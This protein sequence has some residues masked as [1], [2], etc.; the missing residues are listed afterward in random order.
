MQQDKLFIAISRSREPDFLKK[1]PLKCGCS[2]R[3]ATKIPLLRGIVLLAEELSHVIRPRDDDVNQNNLQT[4]IKLIPSILWR[5]KELFNPLKYRYFSIRL[6]ASDDCDGHKI[7]DTA[8]HIWVGNSLG[9]GNFPYLLDPFN[10][11]L[12]AIRGPQYQLYIWG[13]NSLKEDES[14]AGREIATE[15]FAHMNG[16]HQIAEWP[17]TKLFQIDNANV[18]SGKHIFINGYFIN[19]EL[20]QSGENLLNIDLDI[21]QFK[22]LTPMYKEIDNA[23]Y[24]DANSNLYH[25]LSESLRPL[26]LAIERKIPL[27][28]IL[29]RSG[30]P[31]HFYQLINRL[32]P[33][34][35]VITLNWDEKILINNLR[36]GISHK[37]LSS[38]EETFYRDNNTSEFVDSDEMH[39]WQ[40]VNRIFQTTQDSN[41][42][43][44]ISRKRNDSR[45]IW[46]AAELE[47]KLRLSGFDVIDNDLEP[48]Y[49][50][51]I[52]KSSL[53]CS[54]DGAGM[55]N[56]ICLAKGSHVI[57]LSHGSPG[58]KNMS[59]A[60]GL[61]YS[62][63]PLMPLGKGKLRTILDNYYLR[64]K[65]LDQL[66]Q[67][68]ASIRNQD[69][70]K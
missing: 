12:S 51:R 15:I 60:L 5:R 21:S 28:N 43:V 48:E 66:V 26:A 27:S 10:N 17:A 70:D 40:L 54:S 52:S 55:A 4:A 68:S 65:H 38:K 3:E 42:S 44:Y 35:I 20:N 47:S 25:F 29:I 19:L 7:L 32:C 58:W 56:M 36:V 18:I 34:A 11:A 1:E 45:G 30:L 6:I 22:D 46:N 33:K 53:L 41:R 31:A 63:L 67:I 69:M 9:A 59:E 37:N 39:V 23:I 64:Y 16:I 13:T 24:L 62:S 50:S 57:E 49:W 61:E 8:S 2:I 14:N